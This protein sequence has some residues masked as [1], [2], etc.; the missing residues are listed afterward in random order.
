MVLAYEDSDRIS[1]LTKIS[2]LQKRQIEM[3]T[4]ELKIYVK[5]N[6]CIK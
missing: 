4:E 3:A 2:K 5:E 1:E 6:D